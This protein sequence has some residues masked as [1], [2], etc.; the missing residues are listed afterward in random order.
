MISILPFYRKDLDAVLA[1]WQS[2]HPNWAWLNDREYIIDMFAEDEDVE[3]NDFVVRSNGSVI[4]AVFTKYLRRPGWL[5]TRFVQIEAQE[6]TLG[7]RWLELLLE[8]IKNI[9]QR[10]ND[11]WHIVN[12]DTNLLPNLQPILESAGFF[13]HSKVLRSEWS[14]Q[15]IQAVEIVP[16]RFERYVGGAFETDQAIVDLH[17]CAFCR[18]RFATPLRLQR[19]WKPIPQQQFCEYVLAWTNNRLVGFIGWG[20]FGGTAKINSVA[21]AQS[22]RS[23]GLARAL[24]SQVMR[25]ILQEGYQT[26]LATT[27]SDNAA[28]IAA[29]QKLGWQLNREIAHTFVREL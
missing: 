26:I 7:S 28:S 15:F 16:M 3:Q 23:R 10:K 4:A 1:F 27:Q 11:I 12:V 24:A 21:V 6:A 14:G 18:S 19:L 17:E 22:W 29:Q 2:L 9:D 20:F 13:Q 25:I 8:E 5:P